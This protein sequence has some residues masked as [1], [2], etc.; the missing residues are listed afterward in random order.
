MNTPSSS[1]RTESSM[2]RYL[3]RHP[4]GAYF[5]A[6]FAISWGAVLLVVSRG[7]IPV[8]GKAEFDALL[9]LT[10]LAMILGPSIAGIALTGIVDGRTGLRRYRETLLAWRVSAR[11]YVTAALL[12]PV[13]GLVVVSALRVVSPE[14]RPGILA[15]NNPVAY[16][17]LGVGL[18]LLAGVCEELGWTGFAV[19]QLLPRYGIL[20]TGLAVGFAWSAWHLFVAY[21]ATGNGY[22]GSVSA[23]LFLMTGLFT[24]LL[25]YRLL[26]VWV[27]DRTQSLPVAIVMH[28]SLTATVRLVY[29]LTTGSP[30]LVTDIAMAGA[31]WIAVFT[32]AAVG[33]WSLARPWIAGGSAPGG[34]SSVAPS[35]PHPVRNTIDVDGFVHPGFES[36]ADAFIDN[37]TKRK[38]LG[39][40]CCVYHHGEKI[41]DLW[42]GLRN[43]TTGEP[44]LE[45]TMVVVYSATKGMAAMTLALAH[46][47]GWLDYDERVAAYWPEFAQNG[48]AAITVRQLLAHQAGLFAFDEPVDKAAVGDLD[49]LAIILARQ[50]P[51]WKPGTRQSYH[52]LT[53]GFYENELIRRVDPRR[54]SLGRFF[55]DEIATPLDL[56]FYIRLPESI[57]NTRLATLSRPGI[58]AMVR[59][60]PIRTTIDSFNPRSDIR[61]ALIV[62]PGAG[63]VLDANR[64]Y[65]RNLEVPSGGGVGTARAIAHAYS[66]FANGGDELGLTS[67][68]LAE[69]SSPPIPPTHGFWDDGLHGDV[70]F[71]LGFM[72]PTSVWRFGHDGSSFGSPGA[73]GSHGFADPTLGIGYGYVTSGMG[74]ALTGDPR[75]I[76]LREAL[77]TVLGVELDRDR[78]RHRSASFARSG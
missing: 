19:R 5:F 78:E 29:P 39:G 4:A 16:L 56:D 6:T 11:W 22:L 37:F 73:G 68:T 52:A 54:R 3:R 12:A 45:D 41:I 8:A 61:R 77:Y 58:L 24:T 42:G 53:L 40:A 36:V 10:A 47:R 14:Y 28:A 25:V 13:V 7:T 46:S 34:A 60:F 15:A 71:S 43:K 63:I 57:P 38:E 64:I 35:S 26:M 49:R 76:A 32:I 9:P 55:Q 1:T 66:V 65:A 23:P 50:K 48:K 18:S 30:L 44:W 59:G 62:N 67:E 31:L 74:T 51:A 21:W 69:L 70:R 27:Y 33:H 72:R 75:D 2:R 17:S 20:P